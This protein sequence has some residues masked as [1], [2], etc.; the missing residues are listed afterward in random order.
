MRWCVYKITHIPSGR[1]YVG[2]T[3]LDLIVRLHMHFVSMND[4][5]AMHSLMK[6]DGWGAFEIVEL[7]RFEEKSHALAAE[8]DRIR[9]TPTYFPHG[10]NFPKGIP[11]KWQAMIVAREAI[12]AMIEER[13]LADTAGDGPPRSQSAQ[14]APVDFRDGSGRQ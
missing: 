11:A 13:H 6:R 4:G 14:A 9:N 5:S 3:G 8:R 12:D 10:F 1:L 7:E 2:M